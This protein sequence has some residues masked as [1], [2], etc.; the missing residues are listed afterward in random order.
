[1]SIDKIRNFCI[2]AHI[3]HGKS[4]LADRLLEF[5]ET[6]PKREMK[7]Q[8]LDSMEL[9]RER[10]ITIKSHAI[11]MKYRSSNNDEYLL[12]LI[13][14]PGH[15]DFSYEVS[16]SIAACEGALLLIDA[17]Q[18]IQ[19]QTL[20]NLYMALEHNLTIIP[21]IN[22][23]DIPNID[24]ERVK[25]QIKELLGIDSNEILL[26]S[27]KYGTGIPEIFEAIINKIPSPNGDP[28]EPLRAMIFDST[29]D[30][31]RGV[32]VYIRIFSGTLKE[33]DKIAMFSDK[34]T[35]D[36]DEIGILQIK[37]KRLPR[38]NPGEVG[39]VITGAKNLEDIKVG[40]TIYN[41]NR[42]IDKPLKGYKEVKAMVFAG[43]YPVNSENY[44]I[45]KS[46]LA[47]LKLNDA[48][49]FYEPESSN[50]LGFGFRCG[51]LG[52]LH[53]EIIQQRLEREYN[54]EIISTIPTVNY[55][56]R[57]TNGETI[58]IDNP[59]K[60]PDKGEIQNIEEPYVNAQIITPTE[61]FGNILK[62]SK[63]R[64]GVLEKT[65]YLDKKSVLLNLKYPF[66][67]IIF[68][69]FDKLKSVSK[70]Y[71]SF[72]YEYYKYQSSELVKVD[73]LI[74]GVM[75]D[76][77]SLIVHKDKA[78]IWG[79]KVCEKLRHIIPKQLY[80]VTIRAAVGSKIIARET[81]KPLRK[82]VTGKCYGGD[83]TRKRKLLEKQKLGKKR[84]KKL[85]KIEI[86]K[87]AFLIIYSA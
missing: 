73:L 79:K 24:L 30:S 18:G 66:S 85:G 9:E 22:K 53:K 19:A 71:A 36:V 68:D 77:L 20:S 55:L 1:M 32:I 59:S 46:S 54:L 81:I 84:M 3:D 14:T 38:L 63:E 43:F 37:K 27:A 50:A 21:V 80:E 42:P 29:F 86:P 35:Y 44:E 74:S 12:N 76:A 6:I 40:D 39:Y 82:N 4:T 33:K 26:A 5:T 23:I 13:D 10:G 62:I 56:V 11:Q 65:E 7:E 64:R 15:V 48:S 31:Y 58:Y 49:L 78:Y 87:E 57:K 8:I 72:D 61:Y 70:G 16:R 52:I 69:F 45:L 2:I 17:S 34:K 83:I 41:T 60:L 75:V 28:D 25:T 51:F 47:K 67:E